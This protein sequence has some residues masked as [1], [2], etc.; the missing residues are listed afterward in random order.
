VL[1]SRPLACA[2]AFL[3]LLAAG[4]AS[5]KLDPAHRW[6][7][8]RTPHFAVHFHEGCDELAGRAAL[9]AEE[10]H[11]RLAPRIGWTP[12]E[13][14]RLIIADDDDAAGGWAT[15]YP[16]NQILITPTP[17]LG[18][19]G[20]G[21]TRHDD[22]LRLV[23]THEYTHVLQLDMAS[24]LPLALRSVF[25][26]LYFPNSLQPAWLVEGLATFE[27]TEL[28]TGGRGRSPGSAMILLMAALEGP[29]PTLDQMAVLPDAWPAGQVPYL[30]G[31][32][33][34]R[35]LAGRFGRESVANLSRAYGGRPLPFLVESTGR[36]VL[37]EGYRDLWAGWIADLRSRSLEQ[38]R[39]VASLGPTPS[40]P[41]TADG[42]FNGSP[43]WSPDGRRIAWLRADGSAEPGIWVMDADGSHRKPLVRNAFSTTTSAATLR[44]SPDGGRL[45]YTKQGIVRGAAV[46]NDIWA[47]DFARGREIRITRGLRARDADVS[48]DGRTL[49]LVT[50]ESGLTRLALLDLDGQLPARTP[51]RLRPLSEL[52]TD[53][54]AEPRWSADGL[55][56]AVSAWVPGGEKE[57]RVLDR[58]GRLLAR[59]G[60][61]GALDGAPAWSPDG[62]RLYFSSD[63]TG[64]YNIFAWDT[65]TRGIVQVTNVIGGA[66][67]PAS[68]PD[69]RR[70]AFADYTA[71][72]YDIRV[73][74]LEEPAGRGGDAEGRSPAAER[75]EAE[76]E[77]VPAALLRPA[78]QSQAERDREPPKQGTTVATAYSPLDT[79]LPRLWLPWSASSPASGTLV[80]LVTGGQ[81]VLQRH[82]YTFTGLYGPE[83]G[84]L[85]HWLDYT[86]DGLRPTLRLSSSDFDRTSGG[87]L[88]DARGS[89]D[90]TERLRS[91]GA[92]AGLAFPGF[93]SSQAVT[94][95]YRYRELSGLDPLPPWPGYDGELPT[96]GRLGST[97]LAWSFSNA[98]R[99]P[100]AISPAGGRRIG[101]RLEHYQK[102]FGS[103]STFS[104]SSL[105]WSEYIALPSPRHVLAARLFIGGANGGPPQQGV[106]GLGGNAPGAVDYALDDQALLL[107]GYAPNTFR[108]ERAVLA[109][110]EYRF[111]LLEVGRGG[112]SAP[113]YLRRVHGAL[114]ADAGEAWTD[115]AF[116]AGGLH[117]G[118]GAEI[119]FDLFVSYVL[120][121]TVRL[122]VAV[123]LDEE[124]GVY[125]TLGIWIPQGLL[126]SADSRQ[127]PQNAVISRDQHDGGDRR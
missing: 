78:I 121:L 8:I 117:A 47:W 38:Q 41:L 96:T 57:I 109:S 51:A 59:V 88:R 90:Y 16:Y 58:N 74:E 65:V 3:A 108:G 42:R 29:L 85:M 79:L 100:L 113:F 120:P 125:P 106:F 17:P 105:D 39:A 118:V 98:H 94:I 43:A 66:F 60:H 111:P 83:S 9:I 35:Y 25:G 72:G 124:G 50:A 82:L 40:T 116:R 67:S 119:R 49:A 101:F 4:S 26:R 15:P 63:T 73:M 77:E 5:A 61:G 28:T 64:I 127:K 44:W 104:R 10:A 102:G 18:E 110:V 55:R 123:G 37:G 32:S 115:G 107:R 95:G 92:D 76:Q 80:G 2:V 7:T 87:L 86:Y 122:G 84:R 54:F 23:I 19:Y 12:R 70:L 46:V 75:S 103:E 89:A 31:E 69:G 22:W 6:R 20:L 45:Y 97:R 30:F 14:T 36:G 99:Q 68:S 24:R 52:S 34:L 126:G 53:Q 62:R 13:K 71:K 27:E 33:F 21:T 112:V 1:A 48:P 81:D 56:I 91:I 93:D 11:A 114:F